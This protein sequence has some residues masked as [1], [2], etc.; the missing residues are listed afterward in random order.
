MNHPDIPDPASMRCL[1]DTLPCGSALIDRAGVLVHVN[2]RF[3]AM[4]GR[5]AS[6][7]IGRRL[8]DLYAEAYAR[9]RV[10]EDIRSFDA[11]AEFEFTLPQP[12]GSELAVILAGRALDNGG[13]PSALRVLT[14]ID[15]SAQRQLLDTVSDLGDTVLAQAL[16]LKHYNQDLE[17]RVRQRTA[18]LHDANLDA[19]YMLA[20]ACEA[21]DGDTGAHVRRI[22][23][24]ARLVA[25]QLGLDDGQVQ[26]IGY[27][28]VLHDVGK[29]HVPDAVLNKPGPLSPDE[30]RQMQQ[31]TTVGEAILSRRPFFD[32]A[33]QIARSHHENHDGSGYPD[34]LRGEAIPLAARI[35]HL[36]DVFDAL[37][38]ERVYKQAWPP[39]QAMETVLA[40]S[41]RQFD[42]AVA[43]AFGAVFERGDL[44]AA[45][46]AGDTIA[47][48]G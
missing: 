45:R 13:R 41:G 8:A 30:R 5:P 39:K 27:S 3:A 24:Y 14:A 29:L 35:V 9:Q 44:L 12:D 16:S 40:G 19:I 10:A 7:L 28:A 33:R 22:E 17:A 18:E 48:V 21:R 34:G 11:P 36:V 23:R 26:R 20:V 1:L 47:S 6:D 42:P 32:L 46:V 15:I 2:E 4:C 25:A 37:S 43:A 31:H 38:S